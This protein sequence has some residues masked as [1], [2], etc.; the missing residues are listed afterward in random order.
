VVGALL[1]LVIATVAAV[2]FCARSSVSPLGHWM[3]QTENKSFMNLVSSL[4][5]TLV[6]TIQTGLLIDQNH[7]AAGGKAAP[8]YYDNVFNSFN[9]LTL[10]ITLIPLGCFD[11][12]LGYFD[13]LLLQT[14]G[15]FGVAAVFALLWRNQRIRCGRGLDPTNQC[16]ELQVAED[17]PHDLND[18]RRRS[19]NASGQ[20]PVFK[21][22]P[23]E[24]T[25]PS[26]FSRAVGCSWFMVR[27][28]TMPARRPH[29]A[30]YGIIFMKLIL[31]VVSVEIAQAFSCYRF[32]FGGGHHE[33]YL[34]ADFNVNCNVIILVNM[35][36]F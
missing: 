14:L 29:F 19:T 5:T 6:V 34:L 1:V 36:S 8:E 28:E 25:P 24:M 30:R 32:N 12:A 4:L 17:Q 27:I 13:V 20:D 33:K 10:K 2:L 11:A 26:R 18:D 31:P 9:F 16:D 3:K 23:N 15:A 35:F 21:P 7:Q 22:P